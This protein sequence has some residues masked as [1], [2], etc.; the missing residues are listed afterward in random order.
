MPEGVRPSRAL[1]KIVGS[2]AKPLATSLGITT[3]RELLYHFPRKLHHTARYSSLA[4][5]REGEYVSVVVEVVEI[6]GRPTRRRGLY[7]TTVAL[8][9]GRTRGEAV[10]FGRGKK[11]D[12]AIRKSLEPGSRVEINGVAS[13]RYGT[14]QFKSASFLALDPEAALERDVQN[15]HADLE[16]LERGVARPAGEEYLA[17]YPASAE[18]PMKLIRDAMALVLADLDGAGVREALPASVLTE[19]GLMDLG[20]ALHAVHQPTSV[21]RYRE[22][23]HRFRYE[24]AFLLQTVMARRRAQ[25]ATDDATARPG[26]AGALVDSFDAG[27]PFTLT[28]GQREVAAEIATD[29]TQAHP[30][31]RLLQGEVGSGKTVVALRGMLQVVDS[32]GQAA[33]LAPTEVLAHQH[34]R[35]I[36]D[37]LGA[38]GQG[39]ML[40]SAEEATRIALLTGSMPA[41]RRR[42]MLAEIASGAAGIVIGTHALLQAQV[43]FADLGLTVIDEQHRFGVQ[44]REALRAKST[45]MP[46]QLY[47]TATPIPRSVAMTFFGD[48]DVSTLREIPAGRVP[49]TT[50]LVPVAK[51]HWLE[52]VWTKIAEEVE[53]GNR[54][55][56]VAPRI[57]AST[58]E[59]GADLIEPE[60]AASVLGTDRPEEG[61]TGTAA[62]SASASMSNVTQ[63][64]EMLA[65]H[66]V[67]AGTP[68]GVL[69]GRLPAEEKD[70]VMTA[71]AEGRT[72][73]LITTTVV[74]VGVDV[75]E[76]TVMVVL[77][78]D[79]FGL[80]QLHQLRG[81]VGRGSEPGLCL[82]VTAAEPDSEAHQRLQILEQTDD[83]FVLAEKDLKMRKEGDVLGSAQ[84]GRARSLKLLRV[85]TDRALIARARQDARAVIDVDPD[86]ADH[87]DLLTAINQMVDPE[88]EEYLDRA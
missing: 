38:L 6:R 49:V 60:G 87:P 75:P 30:M 86:L 58:E 36:A 67:L 81:R 68:Q 25:I 72:P 52:R 41:G 10:F 27:L 48:V 57:S 20:T 31:Q 11:M 13:H 7:L 45:V 65:E 28:E 51:S 40:G 79:R 8:T 39:G 21:D 19:R 23:L 46:H 26:R 64:A 3:P 34:A 17:V 47:M 71:F 22:A 59:D 66:Q 24:E 83:G 63:V 76:A 61:A 56:V 73:L 33:L 15:L 42:Q 78:A 50:H 1:E 16:A 77:D 80:S 74:E 5:V 53:A 14:I 37:L 43:Q 88:H 35:T 29:L 12:M 55:Y 84:S 4:E 54:A 32:G 18:A 44:Q 62:S 9:D 82:L 70:A 2:A 69:H 85:V